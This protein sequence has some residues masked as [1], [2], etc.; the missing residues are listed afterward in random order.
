MC[1]F[2]LTAASFFFVRVTNFNT[3]TPTT[4]AVVWGGGLEQSVWM[5]HR[6]RD[7]VFF[8]FLLKNK[9]IS[10]WIAMMFS[11]DKPLP[12]LCFKMGGN[13]GEGQHC[14]T[15]GSQQ[16]CIL[17]KHTCTS[18][19]RQESLQREER[20]SLIRITSLDTKVKTRLNKSSFAKCV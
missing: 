19:R 4:V 9:L 1:A 10:N 13:S 17:T 14:S 6:G 11:S 7:K 3:P 16:H 8:F 18:E 5:C 12:L 20:K 2:T 15:R